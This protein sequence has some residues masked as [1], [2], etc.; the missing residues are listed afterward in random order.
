MFNRTYSAL[1]VGIQEA[2]FGFLGNATPAAIEIAT[3][4]RFVMAERDGG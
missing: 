4:R 1:L 3:T 2:R